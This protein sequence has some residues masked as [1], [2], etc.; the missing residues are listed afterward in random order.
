MKAPFVREDILMIL[1]TRTAGAETRKL[2]ETLVER[3]RH[4]APLQQ[5]AEDSALEI[6][7]AGMVTRSD[8]QPERDIKVEAFRMPMPEC[9]ARFCYCLS[10]W[11]VPRGGW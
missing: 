10:A 9:L 5:V 6:V 4:G 3:M 7:D 8:K 2:G 11:R 1:R